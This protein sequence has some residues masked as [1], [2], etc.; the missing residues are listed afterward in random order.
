MRYSK[1]HKVET[2]AKI[3]KHA[4]S[5]LLREGSRGNGRRLI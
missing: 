2:H 4:S 5:Q 1:D 3:V